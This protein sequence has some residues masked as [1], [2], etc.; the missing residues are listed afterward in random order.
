MKLVVNTVDHLAHTFPPPVTA[1]IGQ[2]PNKGL[3]TDTSIQVI[4]GQNP[5]MP[6]SAVA[7]TAGRGSE[8]ISTNR[9]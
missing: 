9:T 7:Y 5:A 3:R 8:S 1:T 6:E 4:V 2:G